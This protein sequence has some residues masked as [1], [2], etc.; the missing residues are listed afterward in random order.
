MVFVEED[1]EFINDFCHWLYTETDFYQKWHA[2]MSDNE[3]DAWRDV[4]FDDLHNRFGCYCC[5]GATKIVFDFDRIPDY[6]IKVPLNC[7]TCGNFFNYCNDYCL[8]E[9]QNYEKAASA[10]LSEFFAETQLFNEYEGLPLYA[11]SKVIADEDEVCSDI[12]TYYDN[13]GEGDYDYS[14]ECVEEW[15]M[16]YAGA[17]SDALCHF[18]NENK[19]N[20]IHTGNVGFLDGSPIIFDYSGYHC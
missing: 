12:R 13:I 3:A 15:L 4:Y 11:Q 9:V 19:I 14:A 10:G 17:A 8:L 7:I 20:D 6:V 2:G 16:D 5:F 18:L 1:R